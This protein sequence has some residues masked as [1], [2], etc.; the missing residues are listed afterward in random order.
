MRIV[1]D[2]NVLVSGILLDLGLFRTIRIVTPAEFLDGLESS[3]PSRRPG[4]P[5]TG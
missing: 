1:Y 2:T 3:A 5:R 4:R